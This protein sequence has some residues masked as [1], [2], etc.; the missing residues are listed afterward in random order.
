MLLASTICA[1]GEGWTHEA[2]SF[3]N[4]WSSTNAIATNDMF[5]IKVHQVV[6][7]ESST[8]YIPAQ[9]LSIAFTGLMSSAGGLWQF[10]G[11]EETNS[12]TYTNDFYQSY[13]PSDYRFAN[14]GLEQTFSI[15]SGV[16]VTTIQRSETGVVTQVEMDVDTLRCYEA[17]MACYERVSDINKETFLNNVPFDTRGGG[18]SI[19]SGIKKHFDYRSFVNTGW[20]ITNNAGIV[21]S[22]T[23]YYDAYYYTTNYLGAI[24]STNY[25]LDR[26]PTYYFA[27]ESIFEQCGMPS[28][29]LTGASV[30][31][32]SYN[33][34]SGPY[35]NYSFTSGNGNIVETH[36]KLIVYPSVTNWTEGMIISNQVYRYDGS[37]VWISG[38]NGQIVSVV[39]TN[40]GYSFSGSYCDTEIKPGFDESDYGWK[41]FTNFIGMLT[42]RQSD[43]VQD[44]DSGSFL[45]WS[46]TAFNLTAYDCFVE[47]PVTNIADWYQ[48]QASV[49]TSSNFSYPSYSYFFT[50][51]K[52]VA[53][54]ENEFGLVA[55]NCGAGYNYMLGLFSLIVKAA[56][57]S[58]PYMPYTNMWPSITYYENRYSIEYIDR[59]NFMIASGIP[60]SGYTTNK[61][62]QGGITLI[63]N[64]FVE[65]GGYQ[66]AIASS[67]DTYW[68]DISFDEGYLSDTNMHDV[69][70]EFC[71]AGS[72]PC[73]HQV[74]DG[75]FPVFK[76]VNFAKD[77]DGTH[78]YRYIYNYATTNG[79]K[80]Y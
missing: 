35:K 61:Y 30:S 80:Y 53:Y 3:T 12:I 70:S 79:F 47:Y 9:V 56:P 68:T 77:Y 2:W 22:W 48:T 34:Y 40:R 31:G 58:T 32:A 67:F 72:I 45:D 41:H 25:Y 39:F 75:C 13:H 64:Q 16:V 23:N 74:E 10:G 73:V 46:N 36:A 66:C 63:E 54:D 17:Y 15:T 65:R 19:L 5:A 14:R 6:T 26:I 51:E 60:A 27:K 42:V 11:S 28:N 52:D 33:K 69:G 24:E 18:I 37:N 21:V 59:D 62:V 44:N 38:T 4:T 49:C 57:R 43:D 55:D 78:P 76:Y 20:K 8:N 71:L 50:Y 29:W 1:H 7:L